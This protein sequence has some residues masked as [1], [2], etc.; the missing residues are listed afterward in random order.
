MQTQDGQLAGDCNSGNLMAA[1]GADADEEGV[2]R[3]GRLG[4]WPGRFDQHGAGVAAPYLA[5]A[6]VLR[7]TK[8]RLANPRIEAKIADE[9]LRRGKAPD[10]ADRSHETGRHNDVHA[11]DG[12]QPLDCRIAENGLRHLAVEQ[13]QILSQAIELAH[14]TF[15]RRHFIGRRLLARA[16]LGRDD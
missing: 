16:A 7:K 1:A 9:L 5:G 8:A 10:I 4:G 14:M 11:S 6:T 13:D 3:T 2:Q 15:D 12:D